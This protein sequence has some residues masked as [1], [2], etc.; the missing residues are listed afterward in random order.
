MAER[1]SICIDGGNFYHLALKKIGIR[2][3]EFDF[4]QFALF[5]AG[6]RVICDGGKRY[7]AGTVRE[8]EDDPKSKEAMSIQNRLFSRLINDHWKLKTS[9]L[10]RRMEEI[11][12]D[13]RTVDYDKLWKLGI[14]KIEQE[15]WRE[16]GIDVKL[17][18]DLIAGALDDKY[19]TVILVSSDGDLI[20]AIDWVR[21]RTKKKVEYVGFSIMNNE[22]ESKSTKPLLSMIPRTDTLRVISEKELSPFILK[23]EGLFD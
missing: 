7:Y 13:R 8:R 19:D 3:D 21:Q 1:V 20:P 2:V 12:I 15:R 11:I 5:L 17:A 9:K 22:D 16:K 23:T 18:T 14:H 10:R 4:V 6:D